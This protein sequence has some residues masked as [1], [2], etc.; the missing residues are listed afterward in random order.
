MKKLTTAV[1]NTVKCNLDNGV[2]S[3]NTNVNANINSNPNV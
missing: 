3:C 1:G 2:L